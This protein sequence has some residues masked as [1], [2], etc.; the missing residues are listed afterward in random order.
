MAFQPVPNVAK[1]ALI[2]SRGGIPMINVFYFRRTGQWGLPELDNLVDMVLAAWRTEVMPNLHIGVVLQR[3]EVR[4]ERAQEDVSYQRPIVPVVTGARG[5]DLTPGN[6]AF[7]VTHTTGLTGRARRGRTYFGGLSEDDVSGDSISLAR[8]N[9]L[10]AGLYQ[11]RDQAMQESWTHVVVSR[12]VNKS[13][14]E[15]AD[16]YPVI[17][18][19]FADLVL[20]SQ[21]RRLIGRGI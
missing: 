9:A 4:G 8:A 19:R 15:T 20:D 2:H 6:V 1:V 3:I 10:V 12:Y 17:G 13:R 5:G 16:V 18:Y 14:R 7:C 11:L 21:R